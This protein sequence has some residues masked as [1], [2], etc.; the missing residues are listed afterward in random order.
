VASQP[1]VAQGWFS[2]PLGQTPKNEFLGVWPKGRSNHPLG[3]W[4]WFGQGMVGKPFG[5]G[6]ATHSGP[7][8]VQLPL[9]PIAQ[10]FI[11][12]RLAQGAAEPP[13][14]PLGVV[15]PP[16][17][18]PTWG[19][20]N[21]PRPNR[22][23]GH[24]LWGGSATPTYIYIYFFFFFFLKKKKDVMG[25]FGNKNVKWVKFPQFESLGVKCHT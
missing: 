25:H 14:G 11:F 9:G 4:G 2:C 18:R 12:G 6:R 5:G 24:H 13:P 15:R 10:I 21:H 23:A 22:V 3:H 8:V 17:D 1:I 16:P 19:W 20:P 7:G